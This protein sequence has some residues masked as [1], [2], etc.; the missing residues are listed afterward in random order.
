MVDGI[1]SG[2]RGVIRIAGLAGIRCAVAGGGFAMSL[3]VMTVRVDRDIHV[4]VGVDR[5]GRV[6]LV[7]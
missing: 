5:C 2:R 7:G 1:R 6:G 3:G 4:R